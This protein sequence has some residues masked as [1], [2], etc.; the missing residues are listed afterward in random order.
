MAGSFLLSQNLKA[1]DR[2][3]QL[4]DLPLVLFE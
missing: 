1:A 3:A 2:E 4:P